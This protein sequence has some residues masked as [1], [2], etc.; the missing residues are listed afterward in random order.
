M[1]QS[2]ALYF[3]NSFLVSATSGWTS[4]A[5]SRAAFGGGTGAGELAILGVDEL[6]EAAAASGA[7]SGAS[8]SEDLLVEIGGAFAPLA[9]SFTGT[10]KSPDG[11]IISP[12]L[13][14]LMYLASWFSWITLRSST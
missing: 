4:G 12:V 3:G 9:I 13:R 7:A 2:P 8:S 11:M 14:A 5:S 6:D 1:I 10:L